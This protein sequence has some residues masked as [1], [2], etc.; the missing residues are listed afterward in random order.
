[1]INGLLFLPLLVGCPLK[2]AAPVTPP[3]SA[4]LAP[5]AAPATP[6]DTLIVLRGAPDQA[7]EDI[8]AAHQGGPL[9]LQ[10]PADLAFEHV[11]ALAALADGRVAALEVE[12]LG[13]DGALF[14]LPLE[15]NGSLAGQPWH[16]TLPTVVAPAP[17]PSEP[18]LGVLGSP[19]EV[20]VGDPPV[21][22][23]LDGERAWV[24]AAGRRQAVGA[25]DLADAVGS[26]Q[27]GARFPV[28]F[29]NA[30]AGTTWETVVVGMAALACSDEPGAV[31]LGG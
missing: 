31:V 27:V 15:L 28:A 23:Y 1:M 8:V 9:R 13:A 25:A 18:V 21:W 29:L 26:L 5:C 12:L 2:K 16:G 22:V 20:S 14:T 30:T 11:A 6:T 3:P 4:A 7:A 17:M 10:A 19:Q 24:D